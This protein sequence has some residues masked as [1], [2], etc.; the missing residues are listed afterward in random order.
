LGDR[1]FF[2]LLSL[3]PD[4][5]EVMER[6]AAEYVLGYHKAARIVEV[7]SWADIWALTDL[8][9]DQVRAAHMRPIRDLQAAV[10][11]ALVENGPEASLLILLD[12]SNLMPVV[13]RRFSDR[14]GEGGRRPDVSGEGLRPES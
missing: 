1:S 9:A 3:S 11:A 2:D 14:E 8:P 13:G 5:K 7:A 10:E 4:P 12:A 6:I